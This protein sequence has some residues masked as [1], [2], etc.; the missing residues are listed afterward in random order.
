VTE[1]FTPYR[2]A[3]SAVLGAVALAY[4]GVI[5][6]DV[7]TNSELVGLILVG[8][9]TFM[10][11]LLP[12]MPGYRLVKLLTNAAFQGLS[13]L[14]QYIDT[15][16]HITTAMWAQLGIAVAVA[17]GIVALPNDPEPAVPPTADLPASA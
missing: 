11:Y 7:V 3:I 9:G 12:N 5:T 15:G 8:L 1:I 4:V 2:A 17:L 16:E 14:I 10:T 13:L 6:D